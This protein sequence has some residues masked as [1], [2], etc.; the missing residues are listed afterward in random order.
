MSIFE[1][2]NRKTWGQVKEFFKYF[3]KKEKSEPLT[4]TIYETIYISLS[5]FVL[6]CDQF[7]SRLNPRMFQS[8]T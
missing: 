4:M 1:L 5:L 6:R 2:D 7:V 3:N 8:K